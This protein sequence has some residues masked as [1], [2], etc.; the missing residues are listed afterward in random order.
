M[1]LRSI[2]TH[3]KHLRLLSVADNI[4]ITDAGVIAVTKA[5]PTLEVL[6]VAGTT[7]VTDHAI[8]EMMRQLP[9]EQCK[10]LS[11]LSFR[12]SITDVMRRTWDTHRASRPITGFFAP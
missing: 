9:L 7:A 2:A 3:C 12:S 8:E 11:L 1:G 10:R 5:C 4:N 6:D